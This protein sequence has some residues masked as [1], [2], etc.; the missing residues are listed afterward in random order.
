MDLERVLAVARD[1]ALAGGEAAVTGSSDL[2]YLSWKA[3]NDPLIGRALDV[4]EAIIDIIH[5]EFSDHAILAEEGP[6]DEVMPVDADPLW[7]VDPICGSTNYL[8]HD[9]HYAI[10][11]AYREAGFYQVGVVYEPERGDLYVGIR[12]GRATLNDQVLHTDQYGEGNEA[13]ERAVVGVDWPANLE[14]RRDM[15]VVANVIANQALGMRSLGSPALGICAVAAGRLHGYVAMGLKLWD[16]AAA[17][18]VLQSAGGIVTNGLGAAWMHSDDGS[19]IAS[20]STIH[21]R[22]ITSFG[23]LNALRKMAREKAST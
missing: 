14:L 11:I 6:D 19:C 10:A 23:P 1:A 2:R 13:I 8:Q 17:S 15:S 21:G 20:N 18:V 9:P 3:P 22:L 5:G 16:V 12:G 7:I 4:Q